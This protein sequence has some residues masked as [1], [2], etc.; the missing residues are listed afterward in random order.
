MATFRCEKSARS[1]AKRDG[2]YRIASGKGTLLLH[3]LRDKLGAKEFDEQ[4]N[5]FGKEYA[6]KATTT[7]AFRAFVEKAVD[8]E[9]LGDFFEVWLDRTGLPASV[10]DLSGPFAVTTFYAGARSNANCLRHVGRGS[11]QP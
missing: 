7:E 10:C 9:E 1:S 8:K 4:M 2:W 3:A 5:R 6:G 11:G